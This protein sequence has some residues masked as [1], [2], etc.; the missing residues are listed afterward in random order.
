MLADTVAFWSALSKSLRKPPEAIQT[1]LYD[2]IAVMQNGV[3]P[4]DDA[5]IVDT[6]TKLIRTGHIHFLRE[7]K[8]KRTG[9]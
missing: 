8:A 4:E 1:T 6:L 2:L 7:T 9:C 3:G 5:L